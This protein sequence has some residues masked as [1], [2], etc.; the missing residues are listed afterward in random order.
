[1]EYNK[2]INKINDKLFSQRQEAIYRREKPSKGDWVLLP[3]GE[4]KRI[5]IISET[6][7]FQL[8]NPEAGRFHIFKS[9]YCDFS[10]SCGD[11]YKDKKLILTD[12]YK[13]GY[14]WIFSKDI[15]GPHRGV[16]RKLRFKVWKIVDEK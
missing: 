14:C 11:L 5:T 12:Q 6:G 15:P 4:M 2:E 7:F 8:N 1:M 10:G 9:G 3:N 16:W 13:E